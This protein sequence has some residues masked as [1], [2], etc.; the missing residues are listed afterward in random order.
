[1]WRLQNPKHQQHFTS[2]ALDTHNKTSTQ[3]RESQSGMLLIPFPLPNPLLL[4]KQN[5]GD[6]PNS[7][8][9][10][11]VLNTWPR[12]KLNFLDNY[13]IQPN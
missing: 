6:F 7:N 9:L 11:T 8:G 5:M 10:S 1:M 12:E 2:V 4:A 13:K 3:W